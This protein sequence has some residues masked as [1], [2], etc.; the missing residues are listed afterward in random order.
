MSRVLDAFDEGAAL[1]SV[2]EKSGIRVALTG[3]A[4]CIVFLIFE[5]ALYDGPVG[6]FLEREK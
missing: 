2:S 6:K 4:Y 5:S 3:L 1:D